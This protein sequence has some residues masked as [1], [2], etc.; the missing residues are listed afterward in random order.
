MLCDDLEGCKDS[1]CDYLHDNQWDSQASPVWLI[2]GVNTFS[3][4]PKYEASELAKAMKQYCPLDDGERD[5]E[6]GEDAA[7]GYQPMVLDYG[8]AF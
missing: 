8:E 3:D 1:S 4:D 6:D 5:S 2:K 7:E